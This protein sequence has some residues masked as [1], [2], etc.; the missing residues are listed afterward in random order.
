MSGWMTL[1]Q[2]SRH[3]QAP[4]ERRGNKQPPEPRR[5]SGLFRRYWFYATAE[6]I[7]QPF[8]K[9]H[10]PA[11]RCELNNN[12]YFLNSTKLMYQPGCWVP[13][14]EPSCI[15]IFYWFKSM[16][17]HASKI[18]RPRV[19]HNEGGQR[20]KIEH[21][22]PPRPNSS[23][24]EFNQAAPVFYRYQFPKCVWCFSSRSM[25]YSLDKLVKMFSQC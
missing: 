3:S 2:T 23:R 18:Y 13:P 22:P 17:L 12:K 5:H 9:H 20:K 6:E 11:F 1:H 7:S 14:A 24:L 19:S 8:R 16:L 25:N 21:L 10:K 4:P 15:R